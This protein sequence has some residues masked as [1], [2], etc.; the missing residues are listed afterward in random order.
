MDNMENK[1]QEQNAC[2]YWTARQILRTKP[3]KCIFRTGSLWAL[4]MVI[5]QSVATFL[6]IPIYLLPLKP[7]TIYTIC[8]VMTIILMILLVF[9]AAKIALI[10]CRREINRSMKNVSQAEVNRMCEEMSSGEWK[11]RNGTI[12]GVIAWIIMVFVVM[13]THRQKDPGMLVVYSIPVFILLTVCL[14]RVMARVTNVNGKLFDELEE[15]YHW[16]EIPKDCMNEKSLDRIF[17][18]LKYG[19]AHSVA[20]AAKQYRFR[21]NMIRSAGKYLLFGAMVMAFEET[22]TPAPWDTADT[23]IEKAIRRAIRRW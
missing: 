7:E 1:N 19:K 8:H 10:L 16:D 3:L 22:D 6:Y 12:L 20:E 23:R 11:P 13:M 9:P 15:G 17:K 4:G 5:L 2:P 14:N 21:R 18:R